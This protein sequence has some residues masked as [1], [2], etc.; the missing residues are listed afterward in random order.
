MYFATFTIP[1]MNGP[2]HLGHLYTIMKCHNRI[3]YQQMTSDPNSYW[4]FGFH[5]TGM[6]I[7]ANAA[8]L[9]HGSDTVFNILKD[10]GVSVSEIKNFIDPAYWIQY[11]PTEATETLSR[12]NLSALTFTDS[13]VTTSR[14][15]YF[16]SFV[17]WQFRKLYSQNLIYSDYRPCIYS[18]KDKQPCAAHDIS[19]GE[20]A[21]IIEYNVQ[22]ID[23]QWVITDAEVPKWLST[24]SSVELTDYIWKNYKAQMLSGT[25]TAILLPS[26]LVISRNDDQCIVAK[27]EQW[28]I[29]YSLPSWKAKVKEYLRNMTIHNEEVR[30]LLELSVDN[31]QSWCF[32]REYGLGTKIPWDNRFMIDSL[33]DST[34]YWVYYT[35][36]HYLHSDI[37]GDSP[38]SLGIKSN[39]LDDSIW[40]YIFGHSNQAPDSIAKDKL[41]IMRESFLSK[42][43]MDLR[44]SGK[45]LINNHLT[46]ALF[47]GIIFGD[48]F[49][50][51]EYMVNGYLQLNGKKMSKSTGN[52]ITIDQ[53]LD[54]YD[55]DSLLIALSEAGDQ[56][57]D[58][59]I[60][61]KDLDGISSA[62]TKT[63]RLIQS[64]NI[65]NYRNHL[66]DFETK[67][68]SNILYECYREVKTSYERGKFKQGL[69]HGWR[70]VLK[71]YEIFGSQ[72]T[73]LHQVAIEIICYTLHP[74]LQ[75]F[76]NP[77]LTVLEQFSIDNCASQDMENLYLYCQKL[78]K[79]WKFS[80]K[81]TFAVKIH[82]RILE[83]PYA[84]EQ[85]ER[86][87]LGLDP[88]LSIVVDNTKLHPKN[89]PFN[90]KPRL[91]SVSRE[92]Q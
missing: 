46:M 68:Y 50:P 36:C 67:V 83:L 63:Y 76:R 41:D 18:V 4:P 20:D 65:V 6:P 30:N 75:R 88:K 71:Y 32:S 86:V 84:R 91:V 13:F 78:E 66:G 27:T 45:D 53:A 81:D 43:P 23:E 29:N 79:M 80:K 44:V 61:L 35:V 9:G 57:T 2:L 85:I 38:G 12:L 56:V 49:L 55:R 3:M 33:S 15:P 89:N 42:T 72:E 10:S 39:E 11:F 51:Q 87:L 82:R 60:Y 62:L 70:K 21:E 74:I 16:D 52:F 92:T 19:I 1:Y 59:N 48:R 54:R 31:L 73:E 26:K 64:G 17:Q 37:Y 25:K 5:C 34:I 90:I 69:T 58:A 8:K 7:Y 40:D 28:Y 47:N 77:D 24:K 14:N 22:L